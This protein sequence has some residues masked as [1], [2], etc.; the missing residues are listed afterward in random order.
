MTNKEAFLILLSH[1]DCLNYE[2]EIYFEGYL[3]AMYSSVLSEHYV[4]T[5]T[6]PF[7]VELV[8]RINKERINNG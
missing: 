8:N 7:L 4:D 5:C 1:L 2:D 6:N 3:D